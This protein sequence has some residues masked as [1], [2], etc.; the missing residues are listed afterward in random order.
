V[1]KGKARRRAAGFTDVAL[2]TL[3]AATGNTLTVELAEDSLRARRKST[4]ASVLHLTLAK[5]SG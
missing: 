5:D 1:V 2:S 3:L 4:E